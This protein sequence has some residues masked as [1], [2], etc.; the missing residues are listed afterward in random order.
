MY[1]QG[2]NDENRFS[3]RVTRP[4]WFGGERFKD[5]IETRSSVKKLVWKPEA[6]SKKLEYQE[7]LDKRRYELRQR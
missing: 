5:F 1:F 3:D 4:V 7:S 2:M 6:R